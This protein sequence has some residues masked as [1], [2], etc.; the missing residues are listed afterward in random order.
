MLILYSISYLYIYI[1]VYIYILDSNNKHNYNDDNKNDNKVINVALLDDLKFPC[2][3]FKVNV[4][5]IFFINLN[6]SKTC[7]IPIH[8]KIN[9]YLFHISSN[10]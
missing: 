1:Y 9:D 10:L 4:V 3:F 8:S 5:T 2:M 7:F 6:Y